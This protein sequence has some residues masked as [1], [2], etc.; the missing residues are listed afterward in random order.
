[1]NTKQTTLNCSIGV[2]KEE[3]FGPDSF[4][5]YQAQKGA[6]ARNIYTYSCE[7]F[8][9]SLRGRSQNLMILGMKPLILSLSPAIAHAS[10]PP[11]S[12]K[13]TLS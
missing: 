8:L 9:L 12:H 3:D 6:C 2:P 13:H 7:L 5:Q 10:A 11:P 4:D 1:M